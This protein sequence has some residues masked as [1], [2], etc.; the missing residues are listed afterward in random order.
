MKKFLEFHHSQNKLL[1]FKINF[2]LHLKN[3][4]LRN[5][6]D[7]NVSQIWPSHSIYNNDLLAQFSQSKLFYYKFVD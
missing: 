6:F 1:M 2:W 7:W 3:R 5:L 4:S